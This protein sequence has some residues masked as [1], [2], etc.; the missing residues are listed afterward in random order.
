MLYQKKTKEKKIYSGLYV[1]HDARA[2]IYKY[3]DL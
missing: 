1:L 2:E 3:V